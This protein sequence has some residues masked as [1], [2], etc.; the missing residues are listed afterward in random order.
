MNI[1]TLTIEKIRKGLKEG[2]FQAEELT[3]RFLKKAKKENEKLNIFI[4]VTEESALKQAKEIDSLVK[5][6]SKLPPLAGVP[7]ALKDNMLMEDEPCTAGSKILKDYKAPY[8]ATVTKRLKRAGA[9]IIGKTNLDEFAM[10]SSTENSA[11]FTTRNPKDPKRVPGG[12]SGGSAAGV[13]AGVCVASLGSDTGGSI[14]Q[15]ASLCGVVGFKPSYGAVSRYGLIAM[16]SS[17]DQIGP[18]AR[19]VEDARKVFNVIKGRDV[20]DATSVD[21]GAPERN[22]PS[23]EVKDLVVGIPREYFVEGIEPGVDSKV[24]EVIEKLEKEGIKMKRINLPH[25]EYAL[26]CYYVLTPSEVSAN[27]ARYD[28]I[29]YGSGYPEAEDLKSLYLENRSKGLGEEVKRRIMIG[30]YA[31]SAG[32]FDAYYLKAQKVRTLIKRDF[33]TAF[34][35]VDLIL[36]PTSPTTAFKIGEKVEDPLSMYLS[37][38]F[39]VPANLAELPAVSLPAG[40]VDGLPVGV[41]LMGNKF[42]E[43]K[44]WAMAGLIEK[45]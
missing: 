23:F 21:L 16:A 37:D 39:T 35:A 8:D 44:V 9:V 32:Y 22:K 3:Q 17:L 24:K 31:L 25:S 34:R 5:K 20:K 41:Q 36:T 18:F 12:S 7:V 15:P 29:R 45:L 1:K 19:S 30:T 38:I 26:P 43:D 2:R 10:G 13:A 11:F 33:D 42:E 6:G 27:L 40:E 14:R 4:T 28:G